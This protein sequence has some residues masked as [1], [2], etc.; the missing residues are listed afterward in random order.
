[1]VP[2]GLMVI[3]TVEGLS[4]EALETLTGFPLLRLPT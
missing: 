3:D 4:H 2:G 1:V